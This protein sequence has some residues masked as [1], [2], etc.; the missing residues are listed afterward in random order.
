MTVNPTPSAW[1]EEYDTFPKNVQTMQDFWRYNAKHNGNRDY[2]GVIDKETGKV[3]WHKQAEIFERALAVGTHLLELGLK[4]G[5][6]IGV[7]CE[8][9]IESVVFLEGLQLYGFVVVFAFNPKLVSYPAFI[10]RDSEVS[11]IYI[12]K[13][14][15]TY[16]ESLFE[17]GAPKT[18][19]FLISQEIETNFEEYPV[20]EG[21]EQKPL[22]EFLECKNVAAFPVIAPTDPCTICYSSGTVGAPKGVVIS[23]KAMVEA[24]WMVACA[25]NVTKDIIHVSFLPIA[26]IL[27][28]ITIS[29]IMYRGGR[30]AFATNGVFGAIDD[31]K[32]VK[33]TAGPMIPFVLKGIDSKITSEMEKRPIA[34]YI[35][36]FANGLSKFCRFFG[37]RSRLADLLIYD[38]IRSVLGGHIE[39]FV[40]AGDTFP[41]DLHERLSMIFNMELICIYGL[42]ECAGAVT[43]VDRHQ[44]EPG[45]VGSLCPNT[46]VKFN[47]KKEILVR[48]PHLFETYWNRPEVT[49][50]SFDDGWFMTGDKGYVDEHGNLVVVGRDCNILEYEPG[51]ELALPYLVQAYSNYMMLTDLYIYPFKEARTFLAICVTTREYVDY[52]LSVQTKTDEEADEL[53]RSPRFCEWMRKI[54]RSHARDEKLPV[55]AYLAAV[56]CTVFPFSGNLLTPTGKQKPGEFQAKF[57]QEIED[58][59]RQVLERRRKKQMQEDAFE[60][61]DEED[62]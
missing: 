26:H 45:T 27:E 11:A 10:F 14:Y 62:E 35:F 52:G 8:N 12:S 56:R 48:S 36:K 58:M 43:I 40:V 44:I 31:M 24:A 25:V 41:K 53:A 7:Y 6:R 17:Q 30:I 50:S 38:K 33:A 29:V 2:G 1:L 22:S 57:A 23:N 42:S 37:F 5:D 3:T 4:K 15:M 18:L 51:V 20:L 54:L 55:C 21:I 60:Y 13:S 39:W 61:E 32:T 34:N 19:K 46:E 49:K 59:K 16:I 9:S 47:E 28:R